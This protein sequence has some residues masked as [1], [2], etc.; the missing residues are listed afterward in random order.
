[1]NK[2]ILNI[3]YIFF[4]TSL[5]SLAGL[6]AQEIQDS[7]VNIADL[8]IQ[9]NADSLVNVAF[10]TVARQD[11]LGGVSTVNV[12][13]LMKKSYYTYS[14]DGLSSFVG[15]YNG[16][17]WGQGGLVLVDGFPRRASD[18]RPSEI[19]SITVL[20]GASAVAL[21]GSKA[22][23]G[24]VLITTK[25]GQVK[26][27]SIDI[28]ANTGLYV[29]KA[30]PN[31]LDAASYMNL[32]NEACRN[33]GISE[34]YKQSEIYN[35]AMKTNPYR[36][37][38]IDFYS[39]DYLKDTYNR[40]DVTGEISGGNKSARYY[41]NFGMS[42]NN[43]L[44]KYGEQ[45]KNSDLQ[46]NVRANVDMDLTSWL[47]ASADAVAI[48]SN[49]YTGR[50]DFWGSSATLRPNWF[51]P[52]IP[53]DMLDP[54]NSSLQTTVDNSNHLIDGKYLLGGTS[55]D[56]TNTFA[57]MLAAGYIKNKNRTFMFNVGMK[58]DL[59]SILKGLSFKTAYSIDYI[60]TYSEAWKVS[61]AVYQPTWSTMNGNDMIIGLTKYNDDTN[62]TNEF[63]GATNYSQTM[64]VSSQFNYN[65]TFAQ[66][67]N[68][69]A[70]LIGWGYQTQNSNDANNTVNGITGSAYHRISNANIGFQASYNY[71]HKY[72]LDFTGAEVHSAKLPVQNRNAFSPTVSLGWRI[73]DENFF[74]NNVSFVNELKLTASYANL[75]QDI[76]ITDYY[77]YKGY[78]D[79]KGGWYQWHDGAA[80]GWTTGSK[81][82]D[83]PE[84]TFIQREEYRLGLD[85][86]LLKGLV[87]LDANYFSQQTNGLLTQGSSTIY[88][89]YFNNWD[90]SFLPYVNY[91][92]D[93]RTGV[94]FTLNL[95]KK[96]GQVESSLGFSGMY[97]T[98]EAVRR[99][100][101]HSDAYQ[102]DEGK[103]L[104]ASWGYICEGFFNDQ[105][106]IDNH[107][108]QTFGDVK[109]GDLKYK[110]VNNDGVIDSKDQVYLGKGGWYA[111]PFTFGVNVTLKWKGFT[112]FALGTGNIGAI[113]FK[114]SSYY[115]V[116]GSSKYSDVVMGRWTEETKNTAT[117]PRLTTTDNSNNFRNSTFWMFKSNRFDLSRVQITYDFPK[118][119]LKSSFVHALSLYINGQS[120]LTISGERK[121][122]ETNIGFAPQCRFFNF[123]L[124]AS[125]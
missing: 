82:G 52:L 3:C 51:S 17:I 1:M 35:T 90:F 50:G 76:D 31:Y 102:Y 6:Q 78:F 32:Y 103:P 29:P 89:S 30:Y 58:A 111:A 100:E 47:T 8:Q 9:K 53:V 45:K 68:V 19:E 59:G 121:L 97:L 98:T 77:M 83:N 118:N 117:Y 115:W 113:G 23:K 104:D 95:N 60:D 105:A 28:R 123:G 71:R 4:A 84:L 11:L 16:N 86:A 61:Y 62:S 56:Q 49:N 44:M 114:N 20:K 88:P 66:Y 109:P 22:A 37:P 124:K 34:K 27:L 57:D 55:T 73:S 41:T 67:H 10:G 69:S 33:D 36:Y 54:L 65:R 107:A 74:R 21:Y 116:K 96:I 125:F 80:G 70:A 93:K 94:D 120:L 79:N 72:Y 26:P 40:S 2:K 12:S 91:N 48:F 122:M 64:S 38:D 7:L 39:S 46:Y 5:F 81:R 42:Y 13:E 18:I 75:H 63:I 15:G 119:I 25:R 24:V 110:D 108:N 14:L 99:D 106:D 92:N 43:S 112:L 87:T 101:V 85:A